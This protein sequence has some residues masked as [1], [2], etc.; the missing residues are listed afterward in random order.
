MM[1][2]ENTGERDMSESL[3]DFVIRGL[4]EH[5]NRKIKET[6]STPHQEKTKIK[7]ATLTPD[8]SILSVPRTKTQP[9][10]DFLAGYKHLV[11]SIMSSDLKGINEE[12]KAIGFPPMTQE[13]LDQAEKMLKENELK[14]TEE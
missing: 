10:D 1:K 13:Q 9:K 5:K 7:G 11:E 4:R 2:E 3:G 14:A 12:L 8:G 6:T